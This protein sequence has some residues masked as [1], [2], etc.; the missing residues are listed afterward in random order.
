MREERWKTSTLILAATIAGAALMTGGTTVAGESG[1]CY[2]AEIAAAIVLPDGSTHAPGKLQFCLTR[3]LS[4]VEAMHH[5]S[6]DGRPI[7]LFRSRVGNSEGLGGN[8]SAIF[9][10][11]KR[12]DGALELQGFAHPGRDG[13][14]T[15]YRVDLK[16]TRV[17]TSWQLAEEFAQSE[18]LILIAAN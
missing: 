15:T 12:H 13:Q 8:P 17:T 4:P 16:R 11:S 1:R 6:V 9:V 10:F 3:Q 14:L 18:E 7:G 2:S 5:T